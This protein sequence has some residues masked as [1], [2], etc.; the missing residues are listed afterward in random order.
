MWHDIEAIYCCNIDLV[1]LTLER[2]IVL[3]GEF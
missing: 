1:I 2:Y 3:D